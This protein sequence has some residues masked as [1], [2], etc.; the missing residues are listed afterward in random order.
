MQPK[1]PA[2]PEPKPP[3]QKKPKMSRKMPQK[4]GLK[5]MAMGLAKRFGG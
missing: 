2:M 1:M 5:K 4:D 3:R